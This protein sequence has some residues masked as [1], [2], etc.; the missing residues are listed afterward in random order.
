MLRVE[1]CEGGRGVDKKSS[2]PDD[3]G[4]VRRITSSAADRKKYLDRDSDRTRERNMNRTR[5][6]DMNITRDRGDKDRDRNT[7]QLVLA[8]ID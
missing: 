7:C 3:E 2:S 6:R 4:T 1:L 5:D 8:V